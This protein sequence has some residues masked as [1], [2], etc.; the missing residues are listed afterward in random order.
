MSCLIVKCFIK[1]FLNIIYFGVIELIKFD[2]Y[3]ECFYGRMVNVFIV[4]FE[5]LFILME[6]MLWDV[7]EE[8]FGYLI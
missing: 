5:S 1:F 6:G 7:R 4:V 8:V 3:F 2:V